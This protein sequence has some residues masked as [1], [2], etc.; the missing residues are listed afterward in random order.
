[1]KFGYSITGMCSTIVHDLVMIPFDCVKQRLQLG[2]YRG[3]LLVAFK[4]YN[5]WRSLRIIEKEGF[6]ALYRA[7]PTSLLMNIPYAAVMVPLNEKFKQIF[8]PTGRIV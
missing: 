7:F 4:K 6:L 8:N 3:K 5:R 2:K 1:M